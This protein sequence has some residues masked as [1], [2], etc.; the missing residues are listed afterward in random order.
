MEF[1]IT[2][3]QLQPK[4]FTRPHEL[5]NK[6]NAPAHCTHAIIPPS[7]TNGGTGPMSSVTLLSSFDIS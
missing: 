4:A 3:E 2:L 6:K 1:Q 7:E 5:K